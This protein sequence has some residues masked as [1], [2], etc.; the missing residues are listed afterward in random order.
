[1]IYTSIPKRKA[2]KPTAA[3][4]KLKDEWEALVKKYE[5]KKPIALDGIAWTPTKSHI[6]HT[7]KMPSLNTGNGIASSKPRMQ[8]TGTK[9]IG[10]GTLHKSNAVPIFSNEE[11]IDIAKM[12]R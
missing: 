9:M 8:Y 7:P 5:P 3:Q 4:R 10:I 1:M 11:A 6:R 2:S 12:R